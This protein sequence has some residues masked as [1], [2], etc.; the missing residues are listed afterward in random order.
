M[1]ARKPAPFRTKT[2]RFLVQRAR[3]SPSSSSSIAL[4]FESALFFDQ[5]ILFNDRWTCFPTV[6]AR[7]FLRASPSTISSSSRE[8]STACTNTQ[9]LTGSLFFCYCGFSFS[10]LF[11]DL[12]PDNLLLSRLLTLKI[13]G[14]QVSPSFCELT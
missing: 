2:A 5:K 8:G 14:W 1:W 7:P 9:G 10:S 3:F 11:S 12:K 13:G 4:R 6:S